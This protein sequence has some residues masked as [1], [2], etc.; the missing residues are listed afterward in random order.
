[1]GVMCFAFPKPLQE[2]LND[3]ERQARMT[4]LHMKTVYRRLEE[5]EAAV[6]ELP[7]QPQEDLV[8]WVSTTSKNLLWYCSCQCKTKDF[9]LEFDYYG[10][11]ALFCRP[12]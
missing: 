2:A 6:R 7:Q 11:S 1:M 5:L 3:K 4:A 12:R 9:L 10:E 8:R